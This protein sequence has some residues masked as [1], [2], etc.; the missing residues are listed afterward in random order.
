MGSIDI[1]EGQNRA[2]STE[3][4]YFEEVAKPYQVARFDNSSP[5]IPN[6]RFYTDIDQMNDDKANTF[7][8]SFPNN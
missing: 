3:R 7:D 6:E 4:A 2:P 8:L 1:V 5:K